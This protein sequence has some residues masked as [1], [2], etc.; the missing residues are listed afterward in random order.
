[1]IRLCAQ[2]WQRASRNAKLQP[3][4][5]PLA[6]F[7]SFLPPVREFPSDS[8]SYY[9][10][11]ATHTQKILYTIR[12]FFYGNCINATA[13]FQIRRGRD[14][15]SIRQKRRKVWRS[16]SLWEREGVKFSLE[17]RLRCPAWF[18]GGKCRLTVY[19]REIWKMET[20]KGNIYYEAAARLS[21]R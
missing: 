8:D 17:T 16:I 5:I 20:G 12:F 10:S 21:R 9:Y 15:N 3:R 2:E 19:D 1:M 18:F 11:S 7:F 14:E 4:K 6:I 13:R